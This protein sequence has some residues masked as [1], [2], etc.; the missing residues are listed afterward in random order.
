METKTRY[1]AE[2]YL[3]CAMEIGER[4]LVGG[5]EVGRVEDTIRRICKAYGAARVDVFTITSGIVATV[6]GDSCALCTQTR[7]IEKMK[8]NF[9]MLEDLN[10]LSRRICAEKPET[11]EI[12]RE[13]ERIDQTPVYPFYAQLM[14]YAMI[15]GSFCALFGG[16][17]KDIAASAVIGML[18]KV[19]EAF[20]QKGSSNSLIIVFLCA[21]AGGI[22]THT[23]VA[24]GAGTNIELISIGDIMLLIPGMA[25]TNSIR[26][27][28]SRD[29]L[30][31][32]M[33]FVE[34]IVLSVLV[35]LGFTFTGFLF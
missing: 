19:I 23:A 14:I 5:A 34:S 35:A 6:Y 10:Q 13:L 4:M 12:T 16:R 28:F 20:L 9:H 25:F 32:V 26:D 29:M 33:R 2:A 22:L 17:V 24:I 30:S 15:A 1:D 31:G 18:L 8:N 11:K 27:I 21:L 7:H 3:Y